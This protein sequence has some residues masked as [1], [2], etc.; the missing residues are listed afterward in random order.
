ME[1]ESWNEHNTNWAILKEWIFADVWLRELELGWGRKAA[2][3]VNE[4]SKVGYYVK[5]VYIPTV[6][7]WDV[8][9]DVSNA[10]KPLKEPYIIWHKMNTIKEKN[11]LCLTMYLNLLNILNILELLGISSELNFIHGSVHSEGVRT[12]DYLLFSLLLQ[13]SCTTS[14]W[15]ATIWSKSVKSIPYCSACL[16]HW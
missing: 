3:S 14:F 4:G 13:K 16:G 9:L 5:A 2:R 15:H 1:F 11:L 10:K 7:Q 8:T 12:V 6:V